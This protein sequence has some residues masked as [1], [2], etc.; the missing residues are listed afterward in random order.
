M[1]EVPEERQAGLV[2]AACMPSNVIL[3][4]GKLWK[5]PQKRTG[6]VNL[7]AK[8]KLRWFVLRNTSL[9]YYTLEESDHIGKIKGYIPLDTILSVHATHSEGGDTLRTFEVSQKEALLQCVAATQEERNEWVEAVRKAQEAYKAEMAQAPALPNP[10]PGRSRAAAPVPPGPYQEVAGAGA[11]ASMSVTA[12]RWGWPLLLLLPNW[13]VCVCVCVLCAA[14][15]AGH[16]YWLQQRPQGQR[17]AP[18]NHGGPRGRRKPWSQWW[19]SPRWVSA[20]L[21]HGGPPSLPV[22][23]PASHTYTAAAGPAGLER[24]G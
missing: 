21:C 15:E 16:Q 4:E 13:C 3:K 17:A 6:R 1:A 2:A 11:P 12:R 9:S 5:K 19:T 24:S 7:S 18:R 20:F 14:G 23:C 10:Q 8:Q 22:L